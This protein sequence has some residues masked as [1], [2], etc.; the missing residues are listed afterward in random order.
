[1]S[2]AIEYIRNMLLSP[3]YSMPIMEYE[4]QVL[5]VALLA[6]EQ[7]EDAEKK[8][9]LAEL[10]WFK[11]TLVI[12]EFWGTKEQKKMLKYYDERKKVLGGKHED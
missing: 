4:K 1:M 11:T 7:K 6:L 2:S 5:G 12:G 8:G 9:R 10:E 3:K